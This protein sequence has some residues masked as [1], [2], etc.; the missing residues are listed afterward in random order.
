M[1][2]G[3]ILVAIDS[4][5][6]SEQVINRACA[7]SAE[8]LDQ[9]HLVHVMEPL[10]FA[11]GA[12]A[13]INLSELQDQLE[14]QSRERI[15]NQAKSHGIPIEN[16]HLLLGSAAA[17]IHDFAATENISLIVVGSHGRSGLALLLGSTANAVLHGAKCDVLALRVK[18]N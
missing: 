13:S 7:I 5:A 11:Y 6:E 2:Y 8:H 18:S 15:A 16:C 12:D 3:K 1:N 14:T 4:S 10:T 9:L 17:E